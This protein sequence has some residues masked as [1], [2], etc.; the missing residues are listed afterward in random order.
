M[1]FVE[2]LLERTVFAR[3]LKI[4]WASVLCRCFLRTHV[5]GSDAS[6][7]YIRA[8][9]WS[10]LTPLRTVCLRY[11]FS[12]CRLYSCTSNGVTDKLFSHLFY[13]IS[14]SAKGNG[15]DT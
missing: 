8:L 14:G 15:T 12:L 2:K 4:K 9:A 1:L 5:D 7:A 11:Q 13:I 3:K 10:P 6:E